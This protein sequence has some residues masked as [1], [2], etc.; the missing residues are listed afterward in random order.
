MTTEA[1]TET[2]LLTP[3]H[4]SNSQLL[5]ALEVRDLTDPA[6]G[7]HAVRLILDDLVAALTRTWP[8]TRA[9]VIRDSPL[10]TVADN[11]DR[12]GYDPAAVTRDSRYSHYVGPGVMLR[13]HT[14]ASIPAALDALATEADADPDVLLV[15][16]GVVHR[17]DAIDRTHVGTP[18][19]VDLWRIGSGPRLAVPDLEE[20]ITTL[21]GTVLPG[22]EW[23]TVVTSHPYTD[24]GRQVDVLID[25]EWLE[26]A[27]CGLVPA[28]L[29]Q[30]S[31]LDPERHSGLALGLGLDRAVMLRKGIPDIRY[32]RSTDPRVAGQLRDLE[33]WRP[34][35]TMPPVRRDISIVVDRDQDVELL[36]D[37]ARAALGDRADDLESV[38]VLSVTGY[39]DL[40]SPARQ[41]L[42]LRT[43]QVNMLVRLVLRPISHTLTDAAANELRDAVYLA[44]H[45]GPVAELI[46]R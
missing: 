20:M 4:L 35:S 15:V 37:R 6:E 23:R 21:V 5:R 46:T 33:P 42:G 3:P 18:H 45:Q 30:R 28:W 9:R 27:E 39:D 32:L 13:S 41:R 31:G 17:R 44:L 25:G 24:D 12:L 2:P 43:D 19:Q 26:L 1:S 16:P 22:A 11:Y 40:P 7:S 14:S 34:V 36:G 29:L 38:A 10:V 8:G